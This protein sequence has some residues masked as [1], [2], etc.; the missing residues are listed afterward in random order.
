MNQ[1]WSQYRGLI[2]DFENYLL[3]LFSP[4]KTQL[5]IFI[6]NAGLDQTVI[7]TQYTALKVE[8]AL[9]TGRSWMTPCPLILVPISLT[10]FSV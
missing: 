2:P 6:R 10:N 3:F 7:S 5:N 4:I 1:S 8:F 9:N